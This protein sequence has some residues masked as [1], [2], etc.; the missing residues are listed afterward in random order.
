MGGRARISSNGL[1]AAAAGWFVNVINTTHRR[2]V[3]AAAVAP[4]GLVIFGAL[5]LG[6]GR[7]DAWLPLAAGIATGLGLFL[8]WK[9]YAIEAAATAATTLAHAGADQPRYRDLFE[10]SPVAIWEND[11]STVKREVDRLVR[12]GV[13]DVGAYLLEHR[14]DA[15]KLIDTTRVLAVNRAGIAMYR[16][17]SADQVT[18]DYVLEVSDGEV[19]AFCRRVGAFVDEAGPITIETTDLC[20][21]GTQIQVRTTSDV[22]E[23][24]RGDWSCVVHIVEDITQ[25]WKVQRE[26]VLS[27]QRYRELFEQSP[28]S[29]WVEDWS[30]VKPLIDDLRDVIGND[31]SEYLAAHPEF[32]AKA[33]DATELIDINEAGW[34]LMGATS[35]EALLDWARGPIEDDDVAETAQILMGLAEGRTRVAI[36]EMQ[37]FTLDNRGI[38][39][40]GVSFLPPQYADNWGRVIHVFEDTT[41]YHA[42]EQKVRESSQLLELAQHMTRHGHF[43]YD[44]DLDR[45]V[46]C[47]DGLARIFGTSP[48]EFLVGQVASVEFVHTDDRERLVAELART[49]CRREPAELSYRIQLPDGTVRHVHEVSEFLIDEN[50]APTARRIGTVHDITETRETEEALRRARDEAEYANRSKSEFLANVSHELRT[51]L[52]AIIG[53]SDVV[54]DGTFGDI[55]NPR[56]REYIGDINDSGR[57]LLELINDILDLSKAEAGRLELSEEEVVIDRLIRQ[58]VRLVRERAERSG[59]EIGVNLPA[60]LPLV[61]VD[62]RK[63]RQVL[64]NLLSNAVKFTPAGG[65]VTVLALEIDSG[66]LDITV[67]DTG[68]G[69]QA[70]DIDRAFEVFGQVDSALARRFE[71]TGLGLP[72][73]RAIVELHDG[74][75][76]INSH[77]DG[78]TKVTVRLPAERVMPSNS[79][80]AT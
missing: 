45:V 78:G 2:F 51:P 14:D 38:F 36:D 44:T 68:I 28:V 63:L 40:R 76:L 73:A 3:L 79:K 77:P 74:K 69:M 22:P 30:A 34:R 18:K 17:T 72:L 35:K 47:S 8:V 10:Q 49:A 59:I 5:G 53:F 16:L 52:N 37:D 33:Y 11:W 39:V 31:V 62:A 65:D 71:G 24:A 43:V 29:I 13:D 64:L 56:Y 12:T 58:S 26:L 32:I 7:P 50:G 41:A 80:R 55:G 66:E 48:E 6:L 70:D 1:P 46:A 9:S 21:D 54:L 23:S 25:Q 42:A 61:N 19:A 15:R 57:H 27:E 67:A 75:L 60:D 4:A 20:P